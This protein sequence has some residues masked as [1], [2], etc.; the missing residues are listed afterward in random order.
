MSSMSARL[1]LR[2]GDTALGTCAAVAAE[3]EAEVEAE[4][5][6]GVDGRNVFRV[7]RLRSFGAVAGAAPRRLREVARRT[8]DGG[9]CVPLGASAIRVLAVS[10]SSASTRERFARSPSASSSASSARRRLRGSDM[11]P[12]I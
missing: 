3:A 9:D 7:T 6:R 4:V 5:P 12:D 8:V 2:F 1:R 10:D 11:A